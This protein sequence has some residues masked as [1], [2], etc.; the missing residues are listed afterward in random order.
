MPDLLVPL[1]KLP[2][3][4]PRLDALAD[5]GIV[6]RRA[7]PFERSRTRRFIARHFSESW[8]DEAE[9]TF[10]APPVHC[11]L[12]VHEKKI[13]GFACI[14]SMRRGFFGP[15]GV[16]PAFRSRGIGAALLLA[17]LHGMHEMGYAY[18]I[19]GAAG[20]VDFY[21]KAVGAIPIPDSVPGAYRD[22]L[23]PDGEEGER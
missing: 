16:D 6:V 15:T 22:M 3:A 13:A 8:A 5:E 9:A 23:G 21:V 11:W 14:E 1:Y 18:A 20:P 2:P 19:I 17:A 7:Y 10:G 12:A 4:Q